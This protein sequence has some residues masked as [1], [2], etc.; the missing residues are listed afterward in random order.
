MIDDSV[1]SLVAIALT[2]LFLG[3]FNGYGFVASRLPPDT[4]PQITLPSGPGTQG[5]LA[6]PGQIVSSVSQQLTTWASKLGRDHPLVGHVF[7]AQ[8]QATVGPSDLASAAALADVV[9]IGET[10][11]NPD[12]H[13]LQAWLIR[14]LARRGKRPAV[15]ME[16][17]GADQADTLA[18]YE[19][20][21]DATAAGIGPHVGWETSGWPDWSIYKPIAEAAFDYG[22]TIYPG[23]PSRG[24]TQQVTD[25]GL[26]ALSDAERIRLGVAAPLPSSL[27]TALANEI[28]ASHCNLIAD[29]EVGNWT[30][31]QRLRD[32]V[33]ADSIIK[34]ADKSGGSAV[35]IAGSGHVRKD[36]AAPYYLRARSS[37]TKVLSILLSEVESG[38]DN[39]SDA[40][41]RDPEGR[42]AVDYVWFTARTDRPHPCEEMR[43][44][45]NQPSASSG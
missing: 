17:I 44:N 35:L 26:R 33:M 37:A 29:T 38:V 9:L 16:M 4:L 23:N 5:S 25:N 30:Q 24:T 43:R 7:D 6:T 22:L 13:K 2:A 45:T 21:S 1:A 28:K 31:V 42:P 3:L 39:P 41:P 14:E 18:S 40:V 34:A 10:H 36:R 15:V 32:A 8:N 27:T 20:S 11:D 19:A 12:H